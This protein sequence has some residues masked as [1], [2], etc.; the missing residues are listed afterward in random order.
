MPHL[1]IPGAAGEH[2]PRLA[3]NAGSASRATPRLA[4]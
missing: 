2:E 1:A 4:P 3:G